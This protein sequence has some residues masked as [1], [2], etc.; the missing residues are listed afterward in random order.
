LGRRALAVSLGA[1]GNRLT[2]FACGPALPTLTPAVPPRRQGLAQVYRVK[3]GFL[4]V[5]VAQENGQ[6]TLTFQHRDVLGNEVHR[7]SR[8]AS[9]T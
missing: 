6:S 7:Y 4:T 5:S 3:G 9:L 1:S 8:A 2:E